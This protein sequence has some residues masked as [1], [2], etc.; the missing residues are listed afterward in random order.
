MTTIAIIPARGNSKGIPRKNMKLLG[1]TPLIAYTILTALTCDAI[2]R[3]Y[4]STEDEEISEF[5]KQAARI[6]DRQL[7]N[8]TVIDR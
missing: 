8:F 1:R 2:D 3:V 7:E 4:V 6:V 5:S